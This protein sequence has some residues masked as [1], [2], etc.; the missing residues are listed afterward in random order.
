M[1]SYL[2]ILRWFKFDPNG[3]KISVIQSVKRCLVNIKNFS[4]RASRADFLIFIAFHTVVSH[5]MNTIS[6]TFN[7][8]QVT[9]LWFDWLF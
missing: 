1:F 3:G 8:D 4:G 6:A 9:L 5:I 2:S 7:P